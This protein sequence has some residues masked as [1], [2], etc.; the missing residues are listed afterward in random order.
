MTVLQVNKLTLK[1]VFTP[2]FLLIFSA[3]FL[4]T[5][6]EQILTR[7]VE[8]LISSKDGLSS[9]IWVYVGISLASAI[10]FPLITAMLA[11]FSILK[12]SLKTKNPQISAGGFIADK[13]E[14]SL[15]ETLRAWG[16]AF[17]WCF[18]FILP[19]VWKF[20]AFILTPYVVMFSK[21]Y[22]EGTVDALDYS[23]KICK[24]YFKR[25]NWWLTVFYLFVPVVLYFVGEPYRLIMKTPATATVLVFVRTVVEYLFHYYM[26]QVFID[27][28][29][30][31]EAAPTT[32]AATKA[33]TR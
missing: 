22:Q 16:T 17:L 11:S 24:A 13:I 20:I 28:I 31:H 15:I 30:E 12:E 8:S 23:S 32:V 14:L 7:K 10:F 1:S 2:L 33:P 5:L 19:G 6:T 27:F 21:K 3:L 25:V 26:I 29:N 4:S 9:M 18:V